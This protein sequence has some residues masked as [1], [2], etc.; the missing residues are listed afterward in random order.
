M[1]GTVQIYREER[2]RRNTVLTKMAAGLKNR[3]QQTARLSEEYLSS[4]ATLPN[5]AQV[6]ELGR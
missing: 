1:D 2:Q 6:K 3:T 4:W 5:G